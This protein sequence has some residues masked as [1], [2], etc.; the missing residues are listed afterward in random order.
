M[1]LVIKHTDKQRLT[2]CYNVEGERS[3]T[4]WFLR[5]LNYKIFKG[6]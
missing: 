5:H 1:W 4:M 6:N 2:R 3:V